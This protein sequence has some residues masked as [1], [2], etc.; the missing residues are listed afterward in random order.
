MSEKYNGWTNFETWNCNLWYENLD[1]MAQE[2]FDYVVEELQASNIEE[3]TE[4]CK[5]RFI[6]DLSD[7]IENMIDDEKEMFLGKN[8]NGFFADL[9]NAS[10]RVIDYREIASHYW[11]SVNKS[12]IE[13]IFSDSE[14]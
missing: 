7:S 13:S 10:L 14:E 4:Q 5:K 8:R 6:K 12:E 3:F 9:I 2:V 11:D 1:D